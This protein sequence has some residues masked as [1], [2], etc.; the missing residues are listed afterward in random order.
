MHASQEIVSR[1]RMVAEAG[2]LMADVDANGVGDLNP[3]IV[4]LCR[5]M[6]EAQE[7]ARTAVSEGL[8]A[9]SR[10]RRDPDEGGDGTEQLRRLEAANR[11]I[12]EAGA[13]LLELVQG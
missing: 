7:G 5:R 11:E 9:I 8:A 3:E 13:R 6:V 2:R 10:A 12:D 4:A 1:D